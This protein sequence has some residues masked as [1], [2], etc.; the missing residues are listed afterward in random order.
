MGD[1]TALFLLGAGILYLMFSKKKETTEEIATIGGQE[2]AQATIFDVATTPQEKSSALRKIEAQTLANTQA[3]ME[4][5]EARKI[6]ALQSG[7]SERY[8]SGI[9]AG[10]ERRITQITSAMRVAGIDPRISTGKIDYSVT[11]YTPSAD[12]TASRLRTQSS[13]AYPISYRYG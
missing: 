8:V 13:S 1:N 9:V 11:H 6:A 4:R 3:E 5:Q 10:S 2:K 7:K 12:V